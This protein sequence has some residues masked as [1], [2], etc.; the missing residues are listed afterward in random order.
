MQFYFL[1]IILN[2]VAGL[3]LL[4]IKAKE[5]TD[6]ILGE[7]ASEAAPSSKPAFIENMSKK[8]SENDVLKNQ[9][10]ILVVGILSLLTGVIKFF[11]VAGDSPVILGDF[12][13]AIGGILASLALLFNCYVNKGSS[14]IKLP[15][16]LQTL[17]VDKAYLTAIICFAVAFL[18]FIMPGVIF[19]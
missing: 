14:K 18:H 12:F 7:S 19:F 17:F 16:V 1:S 8:I 10:F 13:P 3:I 4:N 11:V 5:E 2:L 9:T 6:E 15:G